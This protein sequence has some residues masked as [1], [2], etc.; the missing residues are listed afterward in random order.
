MAVTHI[1]ESLTSVIIYNF[2]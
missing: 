1:S 2:Y